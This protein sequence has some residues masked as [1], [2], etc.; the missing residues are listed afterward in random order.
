ML[1]TAQEA[2][3]CSTWIGCWR[4][5]NF[6]SRPDRM[7]TAPSSSTGLSER[8]PQDAISAKSICV[9]SSRRKSEKDSRIPVV[10]N[11]I[12]AWTIGDAGLRCSDGQLPALTALS[13]LT[14]QSLNSHSW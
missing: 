7:L 3:M 8:A 4:E 1:G 6:A 9:C 2:R 12:A 5:L 10:A 13:H 11:D 14:T